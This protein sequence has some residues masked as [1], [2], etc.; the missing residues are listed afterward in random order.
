MTLR[1]S[2]TVL[3]VLLFVVVA[4]LPAQASAPPGAEPRARGTFPAL[5][6]T[7]L[8]SGMVIPW[9]VQQIPGGPLL[10]T[11]RSSKKLYVRDGS[12]RHEVDFPN[13]NIWASGETGLM[14]LAIDP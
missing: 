11:E 2:R 3:S 10:I 1:G 5:Q 14:G 7:T 6:V 9:D 12:G 4:A 8:A 13:G